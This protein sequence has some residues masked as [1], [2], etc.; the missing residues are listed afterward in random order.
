MLTSLGRTQEKAISDYQIIDVLNEHLCYVITDKRTPWHLP[1]RRSFRLVSKIVITF[2]SKSKSKLAVYTKVEWLWTPH[3]LRSEFFMLCALLANIVGII[4]K[5]ATSDLKQDALDLVDLVN[6]QV[7]RL[8]S[9]SRTKKAITIFGHVGRQTQI[10][11]FSGSGVKLNVE[12]RNPRTPRT[13]FQ[14]IFETFASLLESAVTSL[15]I[16]TFALF[17]WMWKTTSAHKIILALLLSSA[18]IN[19]LYSSRF[20]YDWWLER[21]AGN[22]MTRLGVHP[23]SVMSKAIYVRDIDEAIA[24]STV[25][26]ATSN[27]SDCF[28]TFYEQAI[29][30]QD[31]PS[32]LSAPSPKDAASK[33][34]TKRLHHTRER[35]ATYRHN[36][37]VALRVV[38]R[39]EKEV[40]QNEWERWLQ[41]ELRRCRQV[42]I[43]LRKNDGEDV[44]DAEAGGQDKKPAAG[45]KDDIKLWYEKY[46]TSCQKEQEHVEDGSRGY[47][48]M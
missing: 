11:E 29:Q 28:S 32:S 10:A 24:N 44:D 30:S 36:L 23:S 34:A 25:G 31:M 26:Q 20:A 45:L 39:I 6:D 9:E 8:G 42:E 47:G 38:N 15:M 2:V 22:F 16:W 4:D 27:A 12:A 5:Q 43:L 35:L 37:L 40:V 21:N 3:G 48:V 1:F 41:Q 14:L 19:G 17:R 13:L 18:L 46:C 33:S 7:R